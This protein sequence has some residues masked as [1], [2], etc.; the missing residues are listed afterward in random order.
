MFVALVGTQTDGHQFINDVIEKGTKTIVCEN[1]DFIDE[2][3]EDITFVLVENSREALAKI[4]HNWFDQPAKDIKIIG[5]TGTNG[6]TTITYLLKSIFDEAGIKTGIVGTTGIYIGNEKIPATHTTPESLE[7]CS[8]LAKMRDENVKVVAME[9]SSHA[10]HQHRV[11]GINFD[12]AIFTNLTL[13]HLDYHKTMEDYA[14]SK[15]RLFDMLKDNGLA[16]VTDDS[17]YS[18]L[19]LSDVKTEKKYFVG[20]TAL[21]DIK[22]SNESNSI[23]SSNFSLDFIGKIPK[24]NRGSIEFQTSLLGNFNIDNCAFAA[25][26]AYLMGIDKN[27][28]QTGLQKTHVAPGRMQKILLKNGAIGIVDYAHSPDSLEK[29]LQTC[30]EFITSSKI[31][32][33]KLICVFGCGGDRDKSK[34]PIMGKIASSI[35]DLIIITDDNPRTEKSMDIINEIFEGIITEDKERVVAIPD[36]HEAIKYAV[37]SSKENDIILVAGKGHETYQV[38]GTEKFHFDDVEELEKY[39]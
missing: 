25:G 18:E 6:K 31:E 19:I 1:L 11:D 27:A 13:D 37:N 23:L 32:N 12:A 22:I 14:N 16:L 26:T 9:V 24:A 2:V 38:I 4:S 28:I 29:A 35:A 17:E 7:L 5:V 15:K 33:S 34:R 30:K 3:P 39:A 20:R 21:A 36:R 8:Y 10:L